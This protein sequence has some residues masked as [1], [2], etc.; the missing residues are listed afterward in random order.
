MLFFCGLSIFII[1]VLQDF[2]D[3]TARAMFWV[4]FAMMVCGVFS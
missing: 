4:A 3:D 2:N 1:T